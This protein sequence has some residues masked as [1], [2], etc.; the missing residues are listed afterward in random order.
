MINSRQ[1]IDE[2]VQRAISTIQDFEQDRGKSPL[3]EFNREDDT[4]KLSCSKNIENFLVLLL[5]SNQYGIS[6][7]EKK[8]TFEEIDYDKFMDLFCQM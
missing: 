2:V 8:D 3:F 6:N 7:I 4:P 5:K 1:M